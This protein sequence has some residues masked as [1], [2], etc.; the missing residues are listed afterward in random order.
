MSNILKYVQHIFPGGAKIFLGGDSPP[1]LRSGPWLTD[2]TTSPMRQQPL[3]H[4]HRAEIKTTF[5]NATYATINAKSEP[6]C[7]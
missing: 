3:L 5:N 2:Y 4:I 1:W 7:C 6:V